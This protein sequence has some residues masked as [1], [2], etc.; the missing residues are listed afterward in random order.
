M[1]LKIVAADEKRLAG[2][3]DR[4]T[5]KRTMAP[6]KQRT[7]TG[8][9]P[10]DAPRRRVVPPKEGLPAWLGRTG[11][12]VPFPGFTFREPS[13]IFAVLFDGD[14]TIS[15]C[16]EIGTTRGVNAI[17]I[18]GRGPGEVILVTCIGKHLFERLL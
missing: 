3:T 4:M 6:C 8:E 7:S 11:R 5:A 16:Y 9:R 17:G 2:E 12:Q 13:L 18:Q 14:G 1:P 15:R 10:M